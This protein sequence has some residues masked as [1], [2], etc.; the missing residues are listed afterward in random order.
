MRNKAISPFISTALIIL[1]GITAVYLALTVLNPAV[2]KS[3]DSA[4]LNEALQN[5]KL[6]DNNIREV[7]SESENSK[8]TISLRVTEG[9]YKVDQNINYINFTYR[10]KSDLTVAGQ[11][12]NINITRSGNDLN[13]FIIYTNLQIQG[14]DHFTKGDNSVVILNN[15]TNST[16]NYPIIYVGK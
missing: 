11:R 9:T 1:I 15:G 7:A 13:L 10:M 4:V 16:T 5:L 14:S 3:K 8:R 6:I 2:D 12:N